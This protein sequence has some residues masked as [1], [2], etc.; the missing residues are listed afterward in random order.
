MLC[1]RAHR[2]VSGL[3]TG[4]GRPKSLHPSWLCWLVTH[5]GGNALGANGPVTMPSHV[6]NVVLSRT[7]RKPA[8]EKKKSSG[9]SVAG[10]AYMGQ[11]GRD[12]GLFVGTCNF[13]HL[14]ASERDKC[15]PPLYF[16]SNNSR[17]LPPSS[18]NYLH[19]RPESWSDRLLDDCWCRL[20]NRV[21]RLS[22]GPFIIT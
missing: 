19:P 3:V 7:M 10:N 5:R 17:E 15:L 12:A 1:L 20:F 16:L 6:V 4:R 18:N 14:T 8:R 21:L 13:G 22:C 2:Y 11:L 9:C